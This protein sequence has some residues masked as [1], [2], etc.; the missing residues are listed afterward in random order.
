MAE[1]S[2]KESESAVSGDIAQGREV[3]SAVLDS[4]LVTDDG[5]IAHLVNRLGANA[6]LELRIGGFGK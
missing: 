6:D 4:L 2:G 1:G 5:I 3:G